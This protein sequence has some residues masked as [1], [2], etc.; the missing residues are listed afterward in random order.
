MKF[1]EQVCRLMQQDPGG[2]GLSAKIPLLLADAVVETLSEAKRTLLLTGFSIPCG[3][4]LGVRGET[5]GPS[6]TAN[7]AAALAAIGGEVCVVTDSV[8]FPLVRAALDIRAPEVRLIQFP[9]TAPDH[10]AASLLAEFAPTH[11]V[12][13]ERPGKARDGHFHNM[14]G[15]WIDAMVADTDPLFSLATQS[16]V[17]TIGIGDGGNELGMG[18]L[19]DW[20]EESVPNGAA[21]CADLAGSYALVAGVSNWWGWGLSALLSV[22]CGKLLLPTAE[23]ETRMLDAV[24]R[25]GAVDGPSKVP[26]RSVDG[27][28]LAFHLG[29][30]QDLT[31]ATMREILSRVPAGVSH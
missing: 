29:L 5:D 30:L 14:H 7:L 11:L 16:G 26:A 2:R 19:R 10:A 23:E 28:P 12:A 17:V 21:I 6:G 4:A 8:S 31:N 22:G 3:G 18:G 1:S 15:E 27:I 13:L 25:A 20:I 9:Q 24:L